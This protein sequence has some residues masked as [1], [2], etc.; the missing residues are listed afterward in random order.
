VV[1]T[2][3]NFIKD[4]DPIIYKQYVMERYKNGSVGKRSNTP[5]PKFDFEKPEFKGEPEKVNLESIA[6]LNKEHPARRY[7]EQGRQFPAETLEDLYYCIKFKEWTNAQKHTFDDVTNDEP[8]II[9]P[10]RYNGTLVGY[11]GRSLLPKSKIKYITI[12]LEEDAPKIYGLDKINNK[13]TVYVTEGPFDSSFVRNSIAMC[14][15][16]GDV[17]KWGISNPV[18]IYDNEPRNREIVTRISDTIDRGERVVIWPSNIVEKD[19]NDMFLSGHTV[20]KL[21]ESNIYQG[22][23]GKLKLQTWKRT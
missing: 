9:I 4:Q 22:L 17:G 18:W 14:G 6:S 15:A 10:L 1:K 3:T 13:E 8:R 19:I 20:Q 11:Q 12:M 2:L 7:L 5:V 16:D 23:K 21:I